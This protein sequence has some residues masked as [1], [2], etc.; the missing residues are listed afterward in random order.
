MRGWRRPSPCP[1]SMYGL[2]AETDTKTVQSPDAWVLGLCGKQLRTY[3]CFRSHPE[4]DGATDR[5]ENRCNRGCSCFT[6]TGCCAEQT[7]EGQEQRQQTVQALFLSPKW[8]R[9]EGLGSRHT[10]KGEPQDLQT[11]KGGTC[12]GERSQ[13]WLECFGSEQWEERKI[14]SW[15]GKA[16][17]GAGL[18]VRY[19][20]IFRC[21]LDIQTEI[22][23]R[24]WNT[25]VWSSGSGPELEIGIWKLSALTC[26]SE[27]APGNVLSLVASTRAFVGRMRGQGGW[28]KAPGLKSGAQQMLMKF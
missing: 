24:R 10:L 4:W 14:Y 7:G 28:H 20:R 17:G 15:R 19:M 13:A 26:H 6:I 5:L 25:W 21:V 23:S 12:V 18:G 27:A 2:V 16:V 3:K 22:S 11:A 1:S 8:A 9:R